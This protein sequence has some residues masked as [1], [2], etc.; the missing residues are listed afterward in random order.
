[1]RQTLAAI[2][3]S[4]PP[5][6]PVRRTEFGIDLGGANSIEGLRVLW[7]RIGTANKE[8]S[9]L[10]PIIAVQEHG[11]SRVHLRLVA[12]PFDD[13][14]AAAKLCAVLATRRQACDTAVFDG[15]RLS[16]NAEPSAAPAPRA[17]RHRTSTHAVKREPLKPVQPAPAPAAPPTP[18]R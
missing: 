12:G 9:G 6:V 17:P 13:A 1:M 15:Q 5:E 11:A 16:L 14:A 10:S 7:R 2:D 4:V 18:A 8:L 3:T